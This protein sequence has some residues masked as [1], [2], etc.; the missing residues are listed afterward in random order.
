[1][2]YV[3]L[4]SA[5]ILTPERWLELGI[6]GAVLLAMLVLMYMQFKFMGENIGRLCD[7]IDSLVNSISTQDQT[8]SRSLISNEKDQKEILRILAAQ[9]KIMQDIYKRVVR[10]D[11]RLYESYKEEQIKKEGK[12]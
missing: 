12:S 9:Q 8:V 4:S 5:S 1:M 11:A 6:A 2:K 10:I 3:A 7:K